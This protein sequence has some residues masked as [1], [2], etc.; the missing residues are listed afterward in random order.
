MRRIVLILFV[1][2]FSVPSFAKDREEMAA[3]ADADDFRR[4]LSSQL[5]DLQLFE[6]AQTMLRALY[7]SASEEEAAAA[8]SRYFE[9]GGEAVLLGSPSVTAL[10]EGGF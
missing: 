2:L 4:W 10:L 3:I 6:A 9:G 7:G 5:D 1:F 8:S